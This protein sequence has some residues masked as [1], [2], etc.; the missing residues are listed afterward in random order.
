MLASGLRAVALCRLC[1]EQHL[2]SLGELPCHMVL[3]LGF[4]NTFVDIITCGNGAWEPSLPSFCIHWSL[5]V[6][7]MK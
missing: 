2:G 3:P 7:E 6:L 5:G 1:C 4:C